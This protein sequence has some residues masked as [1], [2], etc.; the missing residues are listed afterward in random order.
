MAIQSKENPLNYT[1]LSYEDIKTQ[2]DSAL[3]ADSRFDNFVDS[4]LYKSV[5]NLFAGSTDLTNYYVER[6]AEE[7]YLETAQHLSS[8][9]ANANNLGYIVRRPI[10]AQANITFTVT[11]PIPAATA[12][13]VI[14]IPLYSDLNYNGTKFK[15][16]NAYQY[17]LNADDANILQTAGSIS[18]NMAEIVDGET[19]ES[20]PISIIQGEERIFE[21]APG[22][23]TGQKWQKYNITDPSFSNYFGETDFGDWNNSTMTGSKNLT[24]VEITDGNNSR[25][26]Y[27]NKRSL[28]AD[29]NTYNLIQENDEVP[30]VCLIKTNK[31]TTV[32]LYFGD[33]VSSS[34]GANSGETIKVKYFSVEGEDANQINVLN[35]AVDFS[36]NITLSGVGNI[37]DNTKTFFKTNIRGGANIEDKESIR[38]NA[39][40]IYQ[41]LDRLVTKVDYSSYLKTLT[42][43]IFVSLAVAWGES[44]EIAMRQSLGYNVTAIKELFNVI[45]CSVLAPTYTT[46]EEIRP[47]KILLGT[48]EYNDED[49]METTYVGY[50]Q[51]ASDSFYELINKTNFFFYI[52]NDI[53]SYMSF[54]YDEGNTGYSQVKQLLSNITEKSQATV[55]NTY[56][57]PIVQGFEIFGDVIFKNFAD[58]P[59]EKTKVLNAIYESLNTLM[60][61]QSQLYISNI[62]D[63]INSIPSVKYSSIYFKPIADDAS[64][65]LSNITSNVISSSANYS[66]ATWN[67]ISNTASTVFYEYL[68]K[69]SSTA[70]DT[71]VRTDLNTVLTPQIDSKYLDI[72]TNITNKIVNLDGIFQGTIKESDVIPLQDEFRTTTSQKR[73]ITQFTERGFFEEFGKTFYDA[74]ETYTQIDGLTMYRDSEDFTKFVSRVK[75]TMQQTLRESMK[76][77]YGNIVNYSFPNELPVIYDKLTFKY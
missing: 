60:N 50:V 42:D 36:G 21:I 66:Q 2:I 30:D 52:K 71:D 37:S 46:E 45:I 9:I 70:S 24:Q 75:S 25:L 16:L 48:G 63:I 35:E 51:G 55:K 39:P 22:N 7:M 34:I 56:V 32:D 40:A 58:I 49:D 72:N 64:N 27:I 54:L 4:A 3:K 1:G 61:F 41:A 20:V 67:N 28:T 65:G 14:T 33:G 31:D 47:K 43:P 62:T 73:R 10:G 8:V 29:Q 76:D 38:V 69:G 77:E 26:Y 12:G 18:F 6:T 17:V 59:T 19:S 44:D 23:I 5:M 53:S 57:T 74:C 15:L 11:G 13:Q 68:T